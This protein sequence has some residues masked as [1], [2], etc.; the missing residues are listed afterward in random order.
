MSAVTVSGLHKTFRMETPRSDLFSSLQKFFG[1]R[2]PKGLVSV[3]T[4]ISFDLPPGGALALCGPNGSGKTTLLRILS[5][6]IAPTGGT[7]RLEGKKACLLGFAAIL[8]DRLSVEENARLCSVFYE[9]DGAPA[10]N[11]ALIIREAGL[12]QFRNAR[13]GDLS[14]GM[15]IRLPFMAALHSGAAVFLVDEALAVGDQEFQRKCVA[16]FKAL[17]S[18]GAALILATHN[19]ELA[20]VLADEVLLLDSGRRIFKGSFKDMPAR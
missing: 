7:F 6:I 3:L 16:K 18:A 14:A 4:D 5:G 15:R 19:L 17:K 9:L 1:G 10:E 12:E 13:A 2:G 20:E 11:A 8:Q